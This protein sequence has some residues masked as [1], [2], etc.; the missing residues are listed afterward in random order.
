[1]SFLRR[2][3]KKKSIQGRSLPA[4]PNS[5]AIY[6]DDNLP[7]PPPPVSDIP[8]PPPPLTSLPSASR[9]PPPPSTKGA[10]PPPPPPAAKGAL[11]PPPPG[12]KG[13][14]P[15]PP[16]VSRIPASSTPPPSR[17]WDAQSPSFHQGGAPP[18]PPPPP[19]PA[20]MPPT[21]AYVEMRPKMAP[22]PPER[23]SSLKKETS[24]PGMIGLMDIQNA[25]SML[26]KRKQSVKR[27]KSDMSVAEA[28]GCGEGGPRKELT[29]FPSRDTTRKNSVDSVGQQYASVH[30]EQFV[31]VKSGVQ[32][33]GDLPP[34][35]SKSSPVT[36]NKSLKVR[37]FDSALEEEELP[38]PPPI[39]SYK[40][41][42]EEEELPPP[43]PIASYKQAQIPPQ[44][45]KAALKPSL[46]RPEPPHAALKPTT[47]RPEPPHSEFKPTSY[48]PQPPHAALKPTTSRPEPPHSEF[49]PNQIS[50]QPPHAALKPT[51]SR[52]EPPHAGLKPSQMPPPP[53]RAALKPTSSRP[54]PPPPALKPQKEGGT[55][56][57]DLISNPD[58]QTTENFDHVPVPTATDWDQIE[59][60]FDL[61]LEQFDIMDLGPAKEGDYYTLETYG[62]NQKSIL[63]AI[64]FSEFDN[65]MSRT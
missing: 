46:S 16:P 23:R 26:G 41:A 27:E 38:P 48:S 2:S 11:P 31:P 1:M 39:A 34:L 19:P 35:P 64:D 30:K 6:E 32:F 60:E 4:I 7:P 37:P 61:L 5:G 65:E 25:R 43:P 53:P 36:R 29:G 20:D 15:P 3:S 17:H 22:K 9:G 58:L 14:P 18:P 12:T 47:S 57:P 50:P 62:S 10:P 54:Q 33:G 63:A 52:P 59:H 44:P 42:L 45:P 40:H 49:K 24:S 51:T 28:D 8:P 56:L 55:Q 21:D 13:A